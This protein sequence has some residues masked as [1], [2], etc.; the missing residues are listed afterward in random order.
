MI[1]T[2]LIQTPACNIFNMYCNRLITVINV[3]IPDSQKIL[4]NTATQIYGITELISILMSPH[5]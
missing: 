2:T 1:F 5:I 3:F 4:A